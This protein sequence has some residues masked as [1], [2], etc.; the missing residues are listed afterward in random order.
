LTVFG[1]L[2]KEISEWLGNGAKWKT[3]KKKQIEQNEKMGNKIKRTSKY[4]LK[5]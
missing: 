1:D 4:K 5:T 2:E 3:G